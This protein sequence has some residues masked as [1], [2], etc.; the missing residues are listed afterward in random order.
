MAVDTAAIETIFTTQVSTAQQLTTDATTAITT[1][2]TA[3]NDPAVFAYTPYAWRI[4]SAPIIS[5]APSFVAPTKPGRG[6]NPSVPALKAF[7]STVTKPNFGTKPADPGAAPTITMPSKPGA[8]PSDSTGP[9][10]VVYDPQYPS[11]PDLLVL[12]N[13]TLPYPT[14]TLPGNPNI[15]R[16]TF[17]AKTPDGINNITLGEYM[18]QLNGTY[19][20][21]SNSIPAAA[22]S[23]WQAW[24]TAVLQNRPLIAKLT[25]IISSYLDTGGAGI[26]ITIEE[27][28]VTR[29]TDRVSAEQRRKTAAVYAT[30]AQRGLTLPSGVLL[31]GL[32]EAR[33]E[34]AE[35][36]GKVATDVAIKNLEL[37]HDHMKFM[38]DAGIKL[39]TMVANM[40]VELARVTVEAMGQAVELTKAV[41]T[42]MVAINEAMTRI[43]LAQWEGYKAAVEVY[44]AQW[45]AAELEIRL[46]EAQIRAEMAKTEINKA[47]VEILNA[48]V[49]ANQGIVD[50]F[51][52]LVE[53]E[54]AKV[55]ASRV[56][57]MGFEASVHAYTAQIE[58]YKAKWE[59]YHWEVDGEVAKS[60]IYESKVAAYT[61]AINGYRANIESYK[62]EVDAYSAGV[63]GTAAENKSKMDDYI[64]KLEGVIRPYVADI[65]A[66]GKNWTAIAEQMRGQASGLSIIADSLFKG[67]A[68]EVQVDQERA[69]EHLSS[70]RSQLEA[71]LQGAAG[72]TQAAQVSGNLAASAL[73]G[74]TAFAGTFASTQ[75]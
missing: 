41:L 52:S 17:N 66:Y 14:I 67:Y 59:G 61:A 33:T 60:R 39:E 12:P 9:V 51:K 19:A 56:R 63:A 4:P 18:A 53:V 31:A 25:D 5:Y 49:K 58:G 3:F 24:F 72:M 74:L 55:E 23:N 35:A 70:W 75:S 16:P 6:A 27:A 32:K 2:F 71:T 69:R 42:G 48:V 62:T 8:A 20:N 11:A 50:Y 21:Y 15:T 22:R 29:A 28:I 73:N 34:M 46:Y 38:I 10:P 37:E 36:V 54:T 45:Q 47:T 40:A 43:Y 7:P 65:D 30:M 1:A 57:V 13:T 44:K 64:T 68:L 26:P